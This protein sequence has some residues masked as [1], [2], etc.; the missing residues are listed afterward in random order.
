MINAL[1][2]LW[3]VLGAL[4]LGATFQPTGGTD[5]EARARKTRDS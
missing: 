5:P 2:S 4:F 1:N 3:A